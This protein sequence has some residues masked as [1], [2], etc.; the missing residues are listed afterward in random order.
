MG[1]GFQAV[2]S[3]AILEARREIKWSKNYSKLV[4][5]HT[6]N[7]HCNVPRNYPADPAL[8]GWVMNQRAAALKKGTRKPIQVA[9]LNTLGFQAVVSTAM[10]EAQREIKWSENYSKLV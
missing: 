2:V 3:T 10:L 7:G 9:R 5:Y 6:S 8:G 4:A 1:L